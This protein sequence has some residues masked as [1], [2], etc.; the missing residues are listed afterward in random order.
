MINKYLQTFGK[1]SSV[2]NRRACTIIK[3]GGKSLTYMTNIWTYRLINFEEIFPPTCLF[4]PTGLFILRIFFSHMHV[5]STLHIYS[6]LIKHLTLQYTGTP[7]WGKNHS[8]G[9]RIIFK[10]VT[11]FKIHTLHVYYNLQIY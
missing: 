11:S 9:Q 2:P 8:T 10:E 6:F 1:Y 3:F 7:N 5:Y 4:H